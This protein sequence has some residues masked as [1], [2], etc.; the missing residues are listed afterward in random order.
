MASL[1]LKSIVRPAYRAAID[2]LPARWHVMLDFLRFHHRLP[3]LE[4]PQTLNEKI[5]WRK[6]YDRDPRLPVLVDKVKAKEYVAQKCGAQFVIPTL[7]VYETA[8]AL[9]FTKPPLSKAP[10][11]LKVNFGSG[12]NI[13]VREQP[14]DPVAIRAKLAAMMKI[15]YADLMEEWAY[16]S[17]P[18]RILVEPY[19]E[20]PEGYIPDFKFH[21]FSGKIF[22]I[23]MIIDRFKSYRINFYDRNWKPLDI[24]AYAKRTRYDG[25]IPPPASLSQ[26]I[27]LAETL[28]KDFPYARIDLYEINGAVKFG[29]FT[30]YPGGGFD[31]FDPLEWDRTFGSQWKQSWNRPGK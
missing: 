18:R 30:L 8:D 15:D 23:E 19:I 12:F 6:L 5:A 22:A 29:E 26:M 31:K 25:D 4:N 3:N 16:E 21:V 10:Y 14:A 13:F 24:R 28:G 11:V 17:V 7:A 20:T 9:D 27:E 1:S 2:L